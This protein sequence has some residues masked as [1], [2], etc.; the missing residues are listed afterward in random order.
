MKAI[1][2]LYVMANGKVGPSGVGRAVR[3]YCRV[4]A[5]I[6]PEEIKAHPELKAYVDTPPKAETKP[7]PVETK[8]RTA[9]PRAEQVNDDDHTY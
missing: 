5:E 8:P 6:T 7:R 9:E 1:A 3:R 2:R 4:G